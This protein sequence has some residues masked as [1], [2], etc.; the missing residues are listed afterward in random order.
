MI[1]GPIRGIQALKRG[2]MLYHLA[3]AHF[4]F[5]YDEPPADEWVAI[6]CETTGL[7]TRHD[8]IVSWTEPKQVE[9]DAAPG[10][11]KLVPHEQVRTVD[12]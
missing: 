6:D 4:G 9:D 3:D 7:D 2:W 11:C 5:M 12:A 8:E 10:K 1:R